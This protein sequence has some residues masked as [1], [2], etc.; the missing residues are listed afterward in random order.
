M[1]LQRVVVPDANHPENPDALIRPDIHPEGPFPR[2]SYSALLDATA[3]VIE[4][5]RRPPVLW[6]LWS[7]FERI[8]Q[9]RFSGPLPIG[10][11]LLIVLPYIITLI[12]I[13]AVCFAVS[14]TVFMRQEIRSA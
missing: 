6:Y 10:Q 7:P 2:I 5:T 13:K 12:A 8:S 3:T 9:E 11:S 14:Y 1:S 4:P